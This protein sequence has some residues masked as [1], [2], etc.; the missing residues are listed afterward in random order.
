M[1]NYLIVSGHQGTTGAVAQGY[2]EEVMTQGLANKVVAELIRMG[3]QAEEANF[4]L[5]EY[6][7]RFGVT[8]DLMQYDFILEIHLNSSGGKGAY[9]AEIFVAPGVEQIEIPKRI[10]SKL[11]QFYKIRNTDK[12]EDGVNFEKYHIL[13][14]LKGKQEVALLEV[15]F[16]DS[17]TDMLTFVN[18]HNEIA[19]AIAQ[20]ITGEQANISWTAPYGKIYAVRVGSVKIKKN[21]EILKNVAKERGFKDAYIELVPYS[22]ES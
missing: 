19:I 4:N 20:G 9:G 7:D 21:A 1:G 10:I 11:S 13:E 15:G 8:Q 14:K 12:I 6:L 18:D 5:Y 3:H 22:K 16:I 17:K 2:I